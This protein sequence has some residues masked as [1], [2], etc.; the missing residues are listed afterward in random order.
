MNSWILISLMMLA[1][2]L[3]CADNDVVKNGQASAYKYVNASLMLLLLM[4]LVL[5]S[6]INLLR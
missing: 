4:L 5:I 2:Y 1:K 6:Y 3:L